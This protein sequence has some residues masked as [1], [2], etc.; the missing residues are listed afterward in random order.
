M[1]HYERMAAYASTLELRVDTY[2]SPDNLELEHYR[3]PEL[4]AIAHGG[5]LVTLTAGGRSIVELPPERMLELLE[6]ATAAEH[7]LYETGVDTACA[8]PITHYHLRVERLLRD[9]RFMAHVAVNHH[10]VRALGPWWSAV[11]AGL[12]DAAAP[13]VAP[14]AAPAA[15]AARTAESWDFAAAFLAPLDLGPVWT[16][17]GVVRLPHAVTAFEHAGPVYL[18]VGQPPHR[19]EL[20]LHDGGDLF[21]ASEPRRVLPLAPLVDWDRR[22]RWVLPCGGGT[23]MLGQEWRRPPRFVAHS[24]DPARPIYVQRG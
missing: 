10:V 16:T 1:E 7:E 22:T 4:I 21:H 9:H 12:R 11:I 19:S 20:Y 23:L 3:G 2:I 18:R 17:G 14:A 13:A 24:L 5:Q 15:A 8:R 6:L